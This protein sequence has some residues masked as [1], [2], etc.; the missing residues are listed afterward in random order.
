MKFLAGYLMR[1]PMQAILVTSVGAL[2]SLLLPPLSYLSGAAVALVALRFGAWKGLQVC[3][4]AA[5][6]VT[7]LSV[8]VLQS[9]LPGPAYLIVVW[10][11]VLA[12]A[13]HLRRTVSLES[14]LG[15][16]AVFGAAM[17]VAV[18]VGVSN[19]AAFWQKV[20]EDL[21]RQA[22]EGAEAPAGM[23]EAFRLMTGAMAAAVTL[24]LLAS[25]FVARWWQ[26]LLYNPGGFQREYHALR[27]GRKFG[28]LTMLT[29]GMALLGDTGIAGP[30]GDLLLV[31]LV[32]HLLH[33]LAVAHALV[34]NAGA[35]AAW[36]VAIYALL[37]TPL[38]PAT[39]VTLAAVGFA[40][41]WFDFRS[42]FG[43]KNEEV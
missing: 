29:A 16:A 26:A 41:E 19:P 32:L 5:L 11:P 12:L 42:F 34:R 28:V 1:G 4:G 31:Y 35:R 30:A 43:K 20:F 27:F 38:L 36:L 6:A 37:I 7:L 3:G 23:E 21:L 40:D 15:L 18:H 33:G 9:A 8:F 2:L 13:V 22:G 17:V 25:L 39:V 24:S 14:A 10:L